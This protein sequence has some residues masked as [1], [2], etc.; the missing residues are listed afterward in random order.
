[1]N[2]VRL[3]DSFTLYH[4]RVRSH[5]YH[6]LSY[7]P[8]P[9]S[10]LSH[11]NGPENR[12][13]W[14]HSFDLTCSTPYTQS[15]SI[16]TPTPP[17]FLIWSSNHNSYRTKSTFTFRHTLHDIPLSVSSNLKSTLKIRLSC[18]RYVLPW[19]ISLL[20]VTPLS[21]FCPD[22]QFDLVSLYSP[23]PSTSSSKFSP[24]I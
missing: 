7:T 5:Q 9:L 22:T 23:Y 17:L 21:F 8:C 3:G 24:V 10:Q 20:R 4:H 1:M 11:H 15:V 16:K 2:H 6:S 19:Q 14:S 12:N 13:F 18:L